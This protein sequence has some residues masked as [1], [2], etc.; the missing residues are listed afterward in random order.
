[1]Y[2]DFWVWDNNKKFDINMRNVWEAMVERENDELLDQTG[3]NN[4]NTAK[5]KAYE[6]LKKLI[7]R[8]KASKEY[9]D[10]MGK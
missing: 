5:K 4:I 2:D 3:K 8:F 9:R 7:F 1:M 10:C 6:Q